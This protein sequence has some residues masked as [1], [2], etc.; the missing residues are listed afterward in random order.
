MSAALVERS[1]VVVKRR[2]VLGGLFAVGSGIFGIV[3]AF[4]LL[5]SMGPVP[6]DSFETTDWRK[7]SILVDTNGRAVHKDTLVI[8]GIMTVFP[9]GF[10]NNIQ[11]QSMDQT[12]LIRVQDTDLTT[13]PG[14]EG[15]APD[16]YVAYS[17]MCTHLGCPVG[18]YEQEL[19]LLV[20]PCHQSMFNV[21]NGAQ[22]QFGPAPR[23]LPQ[24]PL[25]YDANG[26]LIATA[27]YD[28]AVGPGF[29]ERTTT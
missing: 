28:Q 3:A 20:C 18:L 1:A 4:P 23:P 12:V 24:L 13:R 14:R 5:R 29:W 10:Q 27:P 11:S 2:K 22:P 21:R 19:E 16:G 26:Y 7:G 15:W 9:R 6:G 17:K 8:G 25:G